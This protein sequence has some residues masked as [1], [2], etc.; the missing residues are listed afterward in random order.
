M[1]IADDLFFALK[2]IGIQDVPV[3]ILNIA[4]KAEDTK[5]LLDKINKGEISN[6]AALALY[7]K[8][9]VHTNIVPVK[10][11]IDIIKNSTEDGIIDIDESCIRTVTIDEFEKLLKK[12]HIDTEQNDDRSNDT[13]TSENDAVSDKTADSESITEADSADDKEYSDVVEKT[14]HLWQY[15]PINKEEPEPFDEYRSGMSENAGINVI[16]ARVRGKKHKH[17]GT[18]CDDWFEYD[19]CGKWTIA[20]V[21]DGAGSKKYSRIGAA[22][23]CRAAV[24]Y[25]KEK[26]SEVSDETMDK[27]TLKFEDPEFMTGCSALADIIQEAVLKAYDAVNDAFESRKTKYEYLKVVDRDL[28]FRDFSGTLLLCMMVPVL[29]DEK[30]EYFVI[31]CQ[32]GDGIICSVDRNADYDKALRLLGVPDS[33][34][35]SGETDFLTSEQMRHK[36]NLMGKT[37]IMRGNVSDVL[38]MTDGVADD[39]FPNNPQM[40]RLI[41]DLELN[42]ILDIKDTSEKTDNESLSNI[43]EPVRYPWVN[44]NEKLI[45]VQYAKHVLEKT[46]TAPDVLWKDYDLLK[47]AGLS[48]KENELPEKKEERLLRWLDN[49][50]ERGSF[51]DRTLLILNTDMK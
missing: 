41:L 40:L 50:A 17:D 39:Y 31:A 38:I 36:E 44:D 37:K 21:S 10:N 20:A 22:E 1:G 7:L 34:A 23:S 18:N 35:Y 51:D 16:G 46:Q 5:K 2:N 12:E 49:Y 9:H 42:G 3:D 4:G 19:F 11:D 28:E 29:I 13:G 24:S 27:L 43:P 14:A 32:I 33:G 47:N 26:L 8:E 15:K 48:G 25:I 45:A 30:T 6:P